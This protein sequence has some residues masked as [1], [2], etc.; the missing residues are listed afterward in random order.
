MS[1]T[2]FGTDG[3]RG[4]TNSFPMTAETAL[5][6]GMAAGRHFVRH[7]GR[8]TVVI[9]K[10]TRLSGYMI[11]SALVAGFTSVGMDV[12][13]FGPLPTPAVSQ[14]TRSLRADLGVMI[15]ASHNPYHDN[16]IKLFGPDGEKLDDATE[17]KIET[18]MD[19]GLSEQLAEPADI[20]RAKRID[21]A[22]ARY[23]EIVKSTF[24]KEKRL[25]GL[26]IV[27][28]CAN[29]AAYKVAPK[30]LWELGA[31]V[32]PLGVE[33]NGF[34][35]NEDC[36]STAPE[37]LAKEVKTYRADLGIA[38]DGDGDR[39]ILCDQAGKITDGDQILGLLARDWK[40][41]GELAEPAIAATVMSNLGLENYLEDHG[42]RLE[43][44]KVGDRYVSER[45]KETGINLGGEA[46]GH[47]L[48]PGLAPTGDGLIA[49]LQVLRVLV[50]KG[51]PASE[52]L[53]VF[54]PAPQ[55][56]EN[57]RVD[58][59]RKPLE[60]DKVKQAIADAEQTLDGKGRIVVRASG[61]EPVIRVMAEG[62]KAL[63][64]RVVDDV[65]SAIATQAAG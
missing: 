64:R 38:L 10:D 58:K 31:D 7:K 50:E 27:V 55:L 62:D 2:Y 40:Q 45:M 33:P 32:I 17:V 21:D 37:K 61:T 59:A 28:D 20:G 57:V 46:S 49:A 65:K 18:R 26:R 41:R 13:Q 39:V 6:L 12:F 25:S 11:E 3:V 34:N 15:T 35:V 8:H 14:M 42:I 24:P 16:G 47:I 48:T 52:I 36:G 54:K 44:T 29:G 51:K 53:N 63:I 5:R 22:Q 60:A 19:R 43:R 30:V 1:K 23:V 9:G 4:L 56:L